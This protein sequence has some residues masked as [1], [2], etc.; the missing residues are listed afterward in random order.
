MTAV[1]YILHITDVFPCSISHFFVNLSE[2]VL[3]FVN[4]C[5]EIF[6]ISRQRLVCGIFPQFPLTFQ[7]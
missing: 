3:H 6:H 1:L 7:Q 5:R 4:L 2:F